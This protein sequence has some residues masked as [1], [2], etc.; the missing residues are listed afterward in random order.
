MLPV[1]LIVCILQLVGDICLDVVVVSPTDILLVDVII[2]LAS[3]IPIVVLEPDRCSIVHVGVVDGSHMFNPLLALS[4]ATRAAVPV[5]SS[6]HLSVQVAP[7][8]EPTL[9]CPAVCMVIDTYKTP[10]LIH[11]YARLAVSD[12]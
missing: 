12:C 1:P 2:P 5:G 10:V 11:I 6:L 8:S 7:D 4:N 9:M 3:I